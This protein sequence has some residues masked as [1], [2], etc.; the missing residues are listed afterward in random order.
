VE[1]TSEAEAEYYIQVV[2]DNL[3]DFGS[4][5]LF[6]YSLYDFDFMVELDNG[7]AYPRLWKAYPPLR[8]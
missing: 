2:G 6:V 7:G 5:T 1:W 3:V 8:E 4:Y